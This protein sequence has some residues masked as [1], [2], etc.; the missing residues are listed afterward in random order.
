[1]QPA[2]R[3]RRWPGSPQT[4]AVELRHIPRK[5]WFLTVVATVVER[6]HPPRV[7]IVSCIDCPQR[8]QLSEPLDHFEVHEISTD[9]PQVLIFGCTSL[10]ARADRKFLESLNHRGINQAEIPRSLARVNARSAKRSAGVVS[11]GCFVMSTTLN[12]GRAFENFG[13]TPGVTEDIAGSTQALDVPLQDAEGQPTDPRSRRG[14]LGQAGKELKLGPMKTS[15]G[16][17]LILN[18]A[19]DAPAL[20]VDDSAGNTFRE[21]PRL[22]DANAVSEDKGWARFE[23]GLSRG[24]ARRITFSSSSRSV[25]FNGTDGSE[26]G[27]IEI[28]G[29]TGEAILVKN[30]VSRITLGSA[31]MRI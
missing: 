5:D 3:A 28:Q 14:G 9:Y 6:G 10:V 19:T 8:P 1:M 23:H 12:G 25:V 29:M 26:Y 31:S 30:R 16:A 24:S 4:A 22:F 17:T 18:G 13:G 20:F 21:M 11:K 27:A 7:L 15:K 2:R